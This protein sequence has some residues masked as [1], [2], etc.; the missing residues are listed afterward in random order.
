MDGIRIFCDDGYEN[1][2]RLIDI[3]RTAAAANEKRIV[4]C[5]ELRRKILSFSY[6]ESKKMSVGP[7]E[8]NETLKLRIGDKLRI[9]TDEN[10]VGKQGIISVKNCHSLA[11]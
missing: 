10:I 8:D 1:N 2:Q 11:D 9:T 5:C 7:I 3:A 4:I 6:L